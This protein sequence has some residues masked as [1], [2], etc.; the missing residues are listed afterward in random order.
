MPIGTTV[1]PMRPAYY[2]GIDLSRDNLSITALE[3][4]LKKIDPKKFS[5][6]NLY[7]LSLEEL[8]LIKSALEF[9]G[10]QEHR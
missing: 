5:G 9:Y 3:N 8:R 1:L 6:L 4:I 10:E 2:T 7:G